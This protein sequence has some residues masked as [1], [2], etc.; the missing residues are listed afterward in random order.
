[1]SFISREVL[2]QYGFNKVGTNVLISRH[3]TFYNCQFI[4]IGDN[5]R[6]DDFCLISGGKNNNY[7][8]IGNN[9]HISSHCGIWAQNG[10]NIEDFSNISSGCKIYSESDDFSGNFLIGPMVP[11]EYRGCIKGAIF[12][13]KY[14]VIGAESTVLPGITIN[15]GCAIGANSLVNKDCKSWTIYGGSPIRKIKDRSQQ[16]LKFVE[17][18]QSLL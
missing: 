10:I 1:M 11:D 12:I 9:I 4:N 15:E 14:V 8:N 18:Y 6:I 3:A 13:G 7:L 5:V 2:L 16:L 17:L